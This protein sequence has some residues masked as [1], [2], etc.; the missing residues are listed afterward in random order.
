MSALDREAAP[1]AKSHRSGPLAW[2]FNPYVQIAIGAVLVTISEVLLK[3]GA[4]AAPH[5][6]R[7]PQWLS[8]V[9]ALQSAWTWLGILFYILSFVSWLHV[10]RFVPLTIAFS[11]INAVHVLVPIGSWLF[12]HDHVPPQRWLGIVMILAGILLV[13]GPAARAEEKL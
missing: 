3:K 5:L 12:L 6:S 13:V 10:L 4:D 9:A 11:L 8:G 1:P 2:F 7:L